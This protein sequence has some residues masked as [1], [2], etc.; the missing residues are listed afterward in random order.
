[1]D[2]KGVPYPSVISY[3]AECHAYIHDT[4]DNRLALA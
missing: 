4:F 1:M 2:E 3:Y